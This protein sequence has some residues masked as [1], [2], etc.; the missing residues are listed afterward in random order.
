MNGFC[1]GGEFGGAVLRVSATPVIN[2]ES[3]CFSLRILPKIPLSAA[4]AK[5][6]PAGIGAFAVD[7]D[8]P[9]PVALPADAQD[10]RAGQA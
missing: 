3:N 9:T 1:A 4:A 8:V 7:P 6:K 10:S 2:M 5:P